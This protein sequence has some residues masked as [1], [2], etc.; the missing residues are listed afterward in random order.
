MMAQ[1]IIII[2]KVARA[3]THTHTERRKKKDKLFNVFSPPVSDKDIYL[4]PPGSGSTLDSGINISGGSTHTMPSGER[5][6]PS[7]APACGVGI[8]SGHF[9]EID[10][11]EEM[12]H[13]QAAM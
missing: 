11:N 5:L 12:E 13:N 9:H 8:Q 10:M 6:P 3:H 4:H 7:N 1:I 2:Y